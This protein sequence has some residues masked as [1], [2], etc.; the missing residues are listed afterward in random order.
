M[1][2]SSKLLRAL[3]S[4]NFNIGETREF[5]IWLSAIRI[6][7]IC[8]STI[9][10]LNLS[11]GQI[12]RTRIITSYELNRND[13]YFLFLST[14]FSK[15]NKCDDWL[16]VSRSLIVRRSTKA[17]EIVKC[18]IYGRFFGIF[19][20]TFLFSHS[21]SLSRNNNFLTPSLFSNIFDLIIFIYIVIS[22][23]SQSP[24]LKKQRLTME[25]FA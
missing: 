22:P 17:H 16:I 8:L 14:F 10:N 20:K 1:A 11:T 12:K 23:L 13:L 6:F 4:V 21:T 25:E 15:W 5:S 9:F 7:L 18:K 3:I 2:L 19:S 24:L